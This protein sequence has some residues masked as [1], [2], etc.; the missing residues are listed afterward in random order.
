[1]LI[2]EVCQTPLMGWISG[3]KMR[4]GRP[5]VVP[6][7]CVIFLVLGGWAGCGAQLSQ[8][9]RIW[10]EQRDAVKQKIPKM[11]NYLKLHVISMIYPLCTIEN[12]KHFLVA[13]FDLVHAASRCV[14][15]SRAG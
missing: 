15:P 7:R 11:E 4:K 9:M 14:L 12:Q 13:L 10:A 1:M 2:A 3:L 6:E 5:T 8:R